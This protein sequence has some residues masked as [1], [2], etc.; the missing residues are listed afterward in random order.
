MGMYNHTPSKPFNK[1]FNEQ[2][3]TWS[4]RK[5]LLD[6]KA[7]LEAENN[8]NGSEK[9]AEDLKTVEESFV[10]IRQSTIPRAA[11]SGIK[12]RRARKDF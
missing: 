2:Y 6:E 11:Q 7:R 9:I 3:K 8:A 10:H 12:A 4:D 1:N 5:E